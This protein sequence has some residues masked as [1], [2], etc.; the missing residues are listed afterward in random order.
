MPT[1]VII[2][3]V[4]DALARVLSIFGAFNVGMDP[5]FKQY[6]DFKPSDSFNALERFLQSSEK[7]AE[8]IKGLLLAKK[9]KS[10]RVFIQEL[11]PF[12]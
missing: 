12:L 8:Q 5:G 6:F 7:W 3:A 2:K 10:F 9:V 11:H 1:Q 4:V